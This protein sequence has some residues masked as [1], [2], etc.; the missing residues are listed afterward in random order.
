MILGIDRGTTYTK[1]NLFKEPFRSTVRKAS[2]DDDISRGSIIV[3]YQNQRYI[4]GEKGE[5][6][7]DLMKSKD[8]NTLLLTLVSIALSTGDEIINAKIVTGLPIGY[9]GEQKNELKQMLNGTFHN[10]TIN[11]INK[12]IKINRAEVF[13]EAAGAF[14]SV[15]LNNAL[16]IDVG[17]I[18][19]DVSH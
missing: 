15:E 12:S 10:I 16:I 19:V 14:F 13:P 7:T 3:D 4:I 18:S 9:Y 8:K 11:G 5:F 1:T 17:G 2:S 6:E